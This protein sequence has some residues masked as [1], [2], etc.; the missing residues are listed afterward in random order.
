VTRLE[1]FMTRNGVRP[2]QLATAAGI[3]R[4]FLLRVRKGWADPTRPVIKDLTIAARR[5]LHRHVRASELF[6]LGDD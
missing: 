6:E 4:Q 5:M 3:S 2:V 1:D